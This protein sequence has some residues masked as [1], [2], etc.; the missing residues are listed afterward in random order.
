[1]LG[2]LFEFIGKLLDGSEVSQTD[3]RL[4]FILNLFIEP[5]GDILQVAE[6][7]EQLS[8]AS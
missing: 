2:E 3:R 8:L 4:E 6:L 5:F 7:S 1:M